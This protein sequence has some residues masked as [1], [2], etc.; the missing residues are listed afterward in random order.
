[1]DSKWYTVKVQPNRERTVSDRIKI[2]M[3]KKEMS[4]NILV[5]IQ[6]EYYAK[7][8]K[9]TF[10]EKIMYPGY[11]FIE[12]SNIATLQDILRN[13]PGTSG[14]LKDKNGIPSQ[15]RQSELDKMLE[16]SIETAK[17]EDVLNF[18]V[19]EQIQI[20]SGPFDKFK[21]II[22][23]Y[24]KDKSKVKVSVLIFGRSTMVDLTTEQI[25]KVVD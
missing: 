19:G 2:E 13:T 24:N 22:E 17:V 3:T 16:V 7:N 4:I 8:G 21:G 25:T 20:I 5:P 23:E 10:K 12:S 11:I 6:K 1:M 9:K 18:V 14:I 15:L